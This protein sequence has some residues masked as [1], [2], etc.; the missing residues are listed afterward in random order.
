M[1][2]G[3][4]AER[5]VG[6]TFDLRFPASPVRDEPLWQPVQ[7]GPHCAGS[8]EVKERT[9]DNVDR[10]AAQAPWTPS[11]A[12][13]MHGPTHARGKTPAARVGH[14]GELG[15]SDVFHVRLDYVDAALAEL[16]VSTQ[17]RHAVL[18]LQLD[19]HRLAELDG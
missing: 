17:A 16:A 18:R 6:I 10:L 3:H 7:K 4:G 9:H 5:I 14:L 1:E 11:T 8:I 13:R 15:P 19:L 12:R 2:A